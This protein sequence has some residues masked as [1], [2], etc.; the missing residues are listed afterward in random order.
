MNI[1]AK[2]LEYIITINILFFFI[3]E[4]D[5]AQK[6]NVGCPVSWVLDLELKPGLL[7]FQS[8]YSFYIDCLSS[9]QKNNYV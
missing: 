3:N 8:P 6:S 2:I 4:T 9:G 5:E 7:L 1:D